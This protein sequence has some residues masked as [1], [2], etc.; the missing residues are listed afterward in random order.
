MKLNRIS[1]PLLES[2]FED[3]GSGWGDAA[4]SAVDAAFA[5]KSKGFCSMLQRIVSDVGGC[6]AQ[7]TEYEYIKKIDG[8]GSGKK[9]DA[10]GSTKRRGEGE[11]KYAELKRVIDAGGQLPM[12]SKPDG[13]EYTIREIGATYVDKAARGSQCIACMFYI[14]DEGGESTPDKLFT[15]ADF[16][17]SRQNAPST[18]AVPAAAAV[19]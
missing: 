1:L 13:T 5:G 7:T 17:Q 12:P 2:G 10:K 14:A 19:V 11:K 3:V 18:S 9:D 4:K 16:K 8:E 15:A 6:G